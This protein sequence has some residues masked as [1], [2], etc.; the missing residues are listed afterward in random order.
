MDEGG[1]WQ[2]E[3]GAIEE[4]IID[5]FSSIYSSDQPVNFKASLEAMDETVTPE[6]ND[7]LLENFKVEEVE[8][9]LQQMHPTKPPG[10]DGM[11]PIFFQNY[12]NIVGSSVSNCVLQALNTGVM[13]R[14][15]N[16][17]F[18]CLIPKIKNPQRITK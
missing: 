4:V 11:S 16:N 12:W 9:A 1:V 6:M 8:L 5:Y 7:V 15:I 13:P 18:I 17:T 14:G 10:P 2:E 3:Q